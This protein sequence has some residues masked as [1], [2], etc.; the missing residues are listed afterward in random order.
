MRRI[1]LMLAFLRPAW[2][3]V[4]GLALGAYG[5]LNQPDSYSGP[6]PYIPAG[7]GAADKSWLQFM[8]S[9]GKDVRSLGNRVDPL[10]EQYLRRMRAIPQRPL[11]QAGKTAGQD[12]GQMA[13]MARAY[14]ALMG[15]QGQQAFD[16]QGALYDRTLQRVTD[17]ERAGQ[18][19]RGLAMSPY[20]AGLEGQTLSN[21]NID[22]ENSMLA[23]Q[24]QAA[25]LLKGSMGMQGAAG[26]AEMMGAMAPVNARMTAAGIPEQ[27]ARTYASDVSLGILGPQSAWM[28]QIIPYMNQGMGAQAN[29]FG[30]FATANDQEFRNQQAGLSSLYGGIGTFETMRNQP[31][32]WMN[33]MWGGGHTSTMPDGLGYGTID[34]SIAPVGYG[35]L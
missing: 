31:G 8:Q 22:W 17:Q 27:A 2:V 14:A 29:A 18:S 11:I 4:A 35:G 33:N 13:D 10:L 19:A 6:A 16:P 1:R 24:L 21:F 12:Y 26:E 23:R 5:L 32:S 9:G 28:S 34:P 3:G 20:G 25:N 30:Q 7:L 15:E